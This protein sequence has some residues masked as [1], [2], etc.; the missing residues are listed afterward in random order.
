MITETLQDRLTDLVLANS[1]VVTLYSVRPAGLGITSRAVGAV[2]RGHDQLPKVLVSNTA[3][4]TTVEVS[5]GV[6]GEHSATAVCRDLHDG[7]AAE[8]IRARA[9]PPLGITVKIS[10]IA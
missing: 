6:T 5:V 2:I 1:N 8:L 10:S 9:V 3:A 4:G 7:I